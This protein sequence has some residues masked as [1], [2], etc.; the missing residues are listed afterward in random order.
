[1]RLYAGI[2]KALADETRL[3]IM[4]LLLRHKELCVCDVMAVLQISQ[5]KASRHLRYLKNAGLLDDRREGIWV[6]YMMASSPGGESSRVLHA[7]DELVSSLLSDDIESR[8]SKWQEKKLDGLDLAYD[9][10]RQPAMSCR[11]NDDQ[12]APPKW[13]IEANIL[14]EQRPKGLLFL[15]IANSARSQIGEGIARQIAPVDVKVQSAGSK[16]TSVRSEAIAVLS[17]MGI[18]AR[19]HSSKS[20]TDIDPATVDTVITLCSEEECPLF[21][22]KAYRLHWGLPDPVAVDGDQ[23]TRLHAFRQVRD[24]LI[25]RLSVVF[26]GNAGVA[27]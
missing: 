11:L 4:A 5:S 26:S 3:T 12:G 24:E 8:L 10:L 13:L 6:Y 2:F 27:V 20:V 21:L 16:P 25:K 17:E 22:G 15:C 7:I 1:M 19:K 14:K 23:E 9:P 18:D